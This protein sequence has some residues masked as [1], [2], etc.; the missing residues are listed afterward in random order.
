M[1]PKDSGEWFENWF[2]Q[3]YHSLY[4]NRNLEQSECQVSMLLKNIELG[5]LSRVL[6]LGCGSG[7]HLIYLQKKFRNAVGV[8]LSSFLLRQA[9]QSGC[10]QVVQMDMRYLGLK[11]NSF[12]LISLFFTSFGYFAEP[13]QDFQ[14]LRQLSLSLASQGYL[15]LDLMHSQKV[16]EALPN[17][18]EKEVNGEK[19]EQKRFF[20]DG[21]IQKEITWH[22]KDGTIDRFL[23]RVRP[24]EYAQVKQFSEALNLEMIA[25]FGDEA[26]SPF[27]EN[28][29]RMSFLF[30]KK[31]AF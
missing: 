10:R 15:F 4:Q 6:D 21:Y 7:R 30:R 11:E 17:Q 26:G 12:D 28:S 1:S 18:D 25:V 22:R 29:P 23:E 9:V 20:K 27:H 19:V 5:E 24:Y 13:E 16:L 31:E 8:D 2:G 3:D 14:L